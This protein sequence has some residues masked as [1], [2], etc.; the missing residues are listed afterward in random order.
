MRCSTDPMAKP[1]RLLPDHLLEGHRSWDTQVFPA[2]TPQPKVLSSFI[3]ELMFFKL[4]EQGPGRKMS[5]P[6]WQG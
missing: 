4:V 3:F 2:P 6:R 1:C 5:R